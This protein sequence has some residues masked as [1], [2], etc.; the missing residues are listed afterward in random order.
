MQFQI[1]KT[2]KT[3]IADKV[4][5]AVVLEL[6]ADPHFATLLLLPQGERVRCNCAQITH[7]QVWRHQDRWYVEKYERDGTSPVWHGQVPDF[8][9]F[10][11]LL[12]DE[13]KYS[14][15]IVRVLVPAGATQVELEQ[16][17]CLGVEKLG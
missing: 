17:Q 4:A 1:G 2:F 8:L 7:W 12:A 16:L 11:V 15:R 6:D 13:R 10:S 14:N 5:Y 9:T 3:T